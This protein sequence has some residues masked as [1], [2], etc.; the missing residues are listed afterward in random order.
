MRI[1]LGVK[2]GI[3]NNYVFRKYVSSEDQ[4]SLEL[5]PYES[6]DSLIVCL[7]E[8]IEINKEHN[9]L[10]DNNLEGLASEE[11]E[12]ISKLFLDYKI[13]TSPFKK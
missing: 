13:Q 11:K 7:R 4:L 6:L 10:F 12:K 5:M 9:L 3:D 2:K 1:V 8:N